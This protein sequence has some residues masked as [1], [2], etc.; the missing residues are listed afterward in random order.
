M[1]M[2]LIAVVLIHG[3]KLDHATYWYIAAGVFTAIDLSILNYS[4]MPITEALE[5]I[6]N[7]LIESKDI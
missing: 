1:R 7:Q 5:K 6:H 3:L 4:Q 2:L